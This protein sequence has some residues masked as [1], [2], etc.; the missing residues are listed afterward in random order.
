MKRS[1]CIDCDIKLTNKTRGKW[2]PDHWCQSC[3]KIRIGRIS[4]SL[5]EIA[6]KIDGKA[7]RNESET[8]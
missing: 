8:D 1:K 4:E 2:G 7:A 6:A 5:E 3:D